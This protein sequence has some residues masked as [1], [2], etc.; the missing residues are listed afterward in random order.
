M[1]RSVFCFIATVGRMKFTQVPHT[2]DEVIEEVEQ[3]GHTYVES[4]EDADFLIYSGGSGG[5]PELPQ[6]IGFVQYVFAGVEHLIA[7]GTLSSDV[8]WANAGGVYGKPVAEIAMSLL[9]AAYHQ[10]KLSM[11][12]GSFKARWK[13]D[14]RQDWLFYNKTV[15]L[16]GAGGIG[17]AL[18]EML[19]PFGTRIIAVNRSG[20]EIAGADEVRTLAQP[21]DLWEEADVFI[22]STPLTEQTHHIVGK[23]E[24]ARMKESAVVVNVGRGKLLDTNALVDALSSH[25]IA[26]AAMDVTDPEPL[27]EDHP[28]WAMDNVVITPHIAAPPSVARMLIAPQIIANAKA[29][30]AGEEMPSE[31][32]VEAGY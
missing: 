11:Q 16:I 24:L 1:R 5:L 26:A 21:G 31:V 4:V 25:K 20:R 30:E 28:L 23:D 7:D 2:W 12:A 15:A 14:E 19:K 22:L 3:A 29:F 18:I 10:H 6:N 9:L 27:D 32:D 17:Q 13:A 8:R